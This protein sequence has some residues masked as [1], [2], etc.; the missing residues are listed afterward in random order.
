MKQKV[1]VEITVSFDDGT[2][3]PDVEEGLVDALAGLRR[4]LTFLPAIRGKTS[5]GKEIAFKIAD[6]QLPGEG[7]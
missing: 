2:L 3:Q 4:M 7:W 6:V 5:R 1:K